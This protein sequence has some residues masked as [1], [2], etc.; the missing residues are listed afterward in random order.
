MDFFDRW[1]DLSQ[2]EHRHSEKIINKNIINNFTASLVLFHKKNMEPTIFIIYT[3][4]INNK[5]SSLI[6][7]HLYVMSNFL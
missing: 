2:H 7:M 6:G 5:T 1:D 4:H 3:M